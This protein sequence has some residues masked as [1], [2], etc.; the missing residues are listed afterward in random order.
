M[1][2][3]LPSFPDPTT[4]RPE[5]EPAVLDQFTPFRDPR[6]EKVGVCNFDDP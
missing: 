3:K 5:V 4:F 6:V 1:V 2:A